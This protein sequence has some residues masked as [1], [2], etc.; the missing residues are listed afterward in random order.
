MK[1]T[2]LRYL[3]VIL[4]AMGI[5]IGFR[6]SNPE[7]G[8]PDQQIQESLEAF[9]QMMEV[10]AHKRCVNCHPSDDNPRQ[11]EDSHVHLFGV[12][13]G[14]EGQG[15]AALECGTCHQVSNNNIS[16]VPGAPHWHLAPKSMGWQGMSRVE[17][18]QAMTDPAKNGGR[19]LAAIEHH[20]TEDPLVLWVFDPGVNHEGIPR[21]KPPI[22]KENYIAAVKKWIETGAHIPEN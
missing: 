15:V 17:I 20:L 22:S 19:S 21:E 8:K 2:Q 1:W 10:I 7:P 11:G 18:A 4:L 14:P 5:S 16:G 3:I 13:R 9:S 6:P 12:Q